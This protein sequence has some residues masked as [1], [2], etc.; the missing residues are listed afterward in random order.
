MTVGYYPDWAVT[1]LAVYPLTVGVTKS[2]VGQNVDVSRQEQ[3]FQGEFRPAGEAEVDARRRISL[4][5]IGSSEHTRYEVYENDSGEILLVPV[6]SIPARELAILQNPKLHA[7]L[8]RGLEHAAH[9]KVIDRGS[10]AQYL[11]NDGE[12]E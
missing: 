6:V 1:Y 7:S 3:T 2:H 12:T 9:D 8:L 4:G 11:D 10:F 5:K